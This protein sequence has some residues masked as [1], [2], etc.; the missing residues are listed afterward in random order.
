MQ[1]QLRM[2]MPTKMAMT[3]TQKC[4]RALLDGGWARMGVLAGSA[5]RASLRAWGRC[6]DEAL[7]SLLFLACAIAEDRA[8]GFLALAPELLQL[9]SYFV[10]LRF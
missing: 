4:Q 7:M 8:Y 2:M 5:E 10:L 6:P 3:S 9:S 1:F